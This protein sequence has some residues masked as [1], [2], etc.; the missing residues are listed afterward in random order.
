MYLSE[1]PPF[2]PPS[3]SAHDFFKEQIV[4]LYYNLSRKD[5]ADIQS[6]STFFDNLLGSLKKY[7]QSS[8]S[9]E[10][11]IYLIQ[12]FKLL[13]QTRDCFSGKGEHEVSYMLLSIWYKYYP[14]LAIF[15]LHKF[16]KA[17]SDGRLGYGSWRDIKYLCEYL[18]LHTK[19]GIHHPLVGY[20][21]QFMNKELKRSL[22][23]WNGELEDYLFQISKCNSMNDVENL[24]KPN[25]RESLST[26]VKWI[27]REN[28]KF[29][30]IHEKLVIDWFNTYK[31]YMLS[32]FQSY[33]GY[34]AA[35]D[36]CKMRYRQMIAK[37]NRQIDTTEI[38]MCSRQWDSILP[39]HIPQI[40]MLKNKGHLFYN[41][42]VHSYVTIREV[43]AAKKRQCSQNFQKHFEK[44]FFIIEPFDFLRKHSVK[45]PNTPPISLLVKE[46][47]LLLQ[48]MPLMQYTPGSQN[49]DLQ[50][51]IL[52]SQWQQLTSILGYFELADFIP[53]I[54]FSLDTIHNTDAFYTSIGLALLITERSTMG[55]RLIAIDHIPSWVNLEACGDFFSM[56]RVLEKTTGSIKHTHYNYEAAFEFII[57]AID[58]TKMS[59]RKIRNLSLVL[60]QCSPLGEDFHSKIQDLFIHKGLGSSRKKAL[61]MPRMIYWNMAKSCSPLPGSLY[62]L[63][64]TFFL[65]GFSSSLLHHLF[66]LQSLDI[67]K[68]SYDLICKITEDERY[69]ELGN[70][71]EGLL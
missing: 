57:E 5:S 71:I 36:K 33:E 34:Y 62:S 31:P 19:D 12:L 4:Y 29:D 16:V 63:P 67:C 28:K 1:Y 70:Y 23:C 53:M 13:G 55:K 22:D 20:A 46:A 58:D 52:N 44:K 6:L 51:D 26:L 65:S 15:A 64:N 30:W 32:S 69:D 2:D 40:T 66:T 10:Y 42:I 50:I 45:L 37:L 24:E 21:I 17:L 47:F 8:S 11:S 9:A 25:A 41:N 49:I 61:P 18:R 14:V 3:T 59:F 48:K 54:D 56:I 39:Q 35:L 43:P 38:K 27:P 60:F 68:H 7:I